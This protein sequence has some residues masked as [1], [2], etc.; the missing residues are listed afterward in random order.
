MKPVGFLAP[1]SMLDKKPPHGTPCNSCGLCCMASVCPSGQR[2]LGCSPV[3]PCPALKMDGDRSSC[4]LIAD[5]QRY[6]PRKVAAYGVEKI[7]DA[8]KLL[9]GSGTGCDARFNGEPPDHAFYK[10]LEDHDREIAHQIVE[11]LY[12]IHDYRKKD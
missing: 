8:A 6:F 2:V 11:A 7:R 5:P 12:L 10:K 9:I 4:G 3:G 1:R